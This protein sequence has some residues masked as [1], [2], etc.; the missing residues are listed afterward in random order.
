MKIGLLVRLLIAVVTIFLAL[1]IAYVILVK[2]HDVP[3][4]LIGDAWIRPH[5]TSSTMTAGYCA[6]SN[7]TKDEVVIVAARATGIGA[8][9]FHESVYENEMHRM[10]QL[11]ELTVPPNGT[12]RLEPGG[13][14][15]MLF[16]VSDREAEIHRIEFELSNG[17]TLSHDFAV[18][19][20]TK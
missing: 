13:M 20:R 12:L 6:I 7:H 17:E 10:I 3:K 19:D 16:S 1:V 9:E 8:I 2:P 14:H 4:V 5:L 11:E 15:L 18:D